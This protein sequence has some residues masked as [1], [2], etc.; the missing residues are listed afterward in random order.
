MAEE[1]NQSQT[2]AP[3]GIIFTC[4]CT[5]IGGLLILFALLSSYQPVDDYYLLVGD[6]TG[7]TVADIFIYVTGSTW[8]QALTWMVCINF[9]FSG[10]SSVSITGRITYALTRDNAFLFSD[11]LSQVNP[12][13]KSPLRAIMFV[14]VFDA[15]FLLLPLNESSALAYFAIVS[16][17]TLGFQVCIFWFNFNIGVLVV[18][19]YEIM[20]II[21]IYL[22]RFPM[23]SL[24]SSN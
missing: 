24:S 3:R 10:L 2:S 17:S 21:Y 8:G 5:G 22:Y 16:F 1:T 13:F 7:N 4:L 15:V 9:F 6:G 18:V 23:L 19:I 11:W 12:T 20:L 14:F